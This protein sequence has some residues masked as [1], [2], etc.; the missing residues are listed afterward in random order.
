M[1]PDF[2]LSAYEGTGIMS[3]EF[4]WNRENPYESLMGIYRAP[5]PFS[6]VFLGSEKK[7]DVENVEQMTGKPVCYFVDARDL[8]E[9][10][11]WEEQD[12]TSIFK[13]EFK[14]RVLNLVNLLSVVKDCPIYVH[15]ALGMNRS[16][17]ILVAALAI[18]TGKDINSLLQDMKRYRQLITK[19]LKTT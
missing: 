6:N 15:C 12:Y 18:L 1:N 14:P 16:V 5:S 3:S 17:S 7:E 19:Y 4:Y 13:N 8:P 10:D 11:I 9:L 2:K